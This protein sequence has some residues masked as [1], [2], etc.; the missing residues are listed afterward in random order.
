MDGNLARA[1]GTR[2]PRSKS[3][4]GTFFA[5]QLRPSD[6]EIVRRVQQVAQKHGW[7]MAQVAL[8]WSSTKVSSPIIGANSV[9]AYL[10]TLLLC[11]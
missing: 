8:A 3:L 1:P 10:L 11:A 7:T 5:K 4:E 9:G 2:T 6:E